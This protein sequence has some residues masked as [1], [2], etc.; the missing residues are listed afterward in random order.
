MRFDGPGASSV[1]ID[2][3][4]DSTGRP[5]SFG[6]ALQNSSSVTITNNSFNGANTLVNNLG[7][8]TWSSSNNYCGTGPTR[9]AC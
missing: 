4:T 6:V 1:T 7:N 3:N 9:H 8:S 2:S 5:N